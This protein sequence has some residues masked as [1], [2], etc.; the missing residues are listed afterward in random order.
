M[1]IEM[2]RHGKV[3]MIWR[4]KYTSMEYDSDCKQY[5]LSNIVPLTEKFTDGATD[6][7]I[8]ISELSR[9][10]ET[11]RQL[12]RRTDFYKTKLFNE[13]PVKSYKNSTK[14]HSLFMWNVIGRLQWL[15]NND[16]QME[17][18]KQTILRARKAI[19]LLEEK[20]KDCFVVTHGFYMRVL[21]KELK[22]K[23]Y[24]IKKT[25]KLRISNLDRIIAYK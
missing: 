18:R 19:H 10:Y 24:K 7:M 20:N 22:R 6:K 4:K 11:A 2:I 14:V 12:F 1:E 5:N 17:T 9:T 3:D 23:E 16:R 15:F 21:L 13:V 25:K 8:Y